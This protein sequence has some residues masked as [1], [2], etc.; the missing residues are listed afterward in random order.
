MANGSVSFDELLLIIKQIG[1]F[2]LR[3]MGLRYGFMEMLLMRLAFDNLRV[4]PK[5]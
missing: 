1:A 2:A 3:V 4:V 5:F